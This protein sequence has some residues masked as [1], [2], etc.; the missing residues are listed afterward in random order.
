M[1]KK[2][3][4]RLCAMAIAGA[5]M[6]A[7]LGMNV[8]AADATDVHFTKT[9][10]MRGAQGASTPDVTFTYTIEPGQG[11][12]ATENNPEILP[13]VDGA[14]VEEAVFTHTDADLTDEVSVDFS[15]VNFTKPGIYRYVIKEQ[16]STNV[17]ITN[18]TNDTRYLDV[19]VVNDGQDGYKIANS[20]L[21]A[22][23]RTPDNDGNYGIENKSDGYTNSYKTY[24]LTLKKVIKG[25]MADMN[26]KFD[27]TVTFVG[28]S[29]NA[30][31]TFGGQTVILDADG[32]GSVAVSLGNNETV[33][34]TGIPSTVNYTITENIET[35]E[36]YDTSYTVNGG[37]SVK[38]TST[39]EVTIGKDD[40]SVVF[41]N[42][43]DAVTPTG[44]IMTVAPFVV[45]IAL[46]AAV[47]VLFFR[48]KRNAGF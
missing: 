32:K 20:V 26:K 10:D 45:L 2:T 24:A 28:G 38:G 42:Q 33:T 19:Y 37:D 8:N 29:A 35:K 16:T 43:K 21:L 5:M 14:T 41:T 4:S 46:A 39:D 13:G 11:V 47:A 15:R 31:F 34:F 3:T 30:S 9:L 36:G 48:K 12:G 40:D 1:R 23:E 25:D 27:F 17:D 22:S 44:V 18:D 7:T 6:A